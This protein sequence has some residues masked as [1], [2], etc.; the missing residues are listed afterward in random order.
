MYRMEVQTHLRMMDYLEERLKSGESVALHVS[1]L[2]DDE[3]AMPGRHFRMY[4]K[5]R[6]TKLLA[7]TA[8]LPQDLHCM[9]ALVA[10]ERYR[11]KHGDF[12][13]RWSDLVPVLLQEVPKEAGKPYILKHDP[14]GLVI[15]RIGYREKDLGGKVLRKYNPESN[16]TDSEID[17]GLMIFYPKYRRQPP[18]PVKPKAKSEE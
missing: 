18:P 6:W 17:D 13:R 4:F 2:L 5:P 1:D 15:Y 9:E 8:T 10:A 12:P 16:E 3:N 14:G 11:L 7:D